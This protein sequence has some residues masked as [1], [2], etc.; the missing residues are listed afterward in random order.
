MANGTLTFG[1]F[2]LLTV[3]FALLLYSHESVTNTSKGNGGDTR[4]SARLWAMLGL[5]VAV[6][7][8]LG[9]LLGIQPGL[10]EA[11]IVF[12]AAMWTLYGFGKLAIPQ[13]LFRIEYLA[14]VWGGGELLTDDGEQAQR[15]IGYLYLLMGYVFFLLPL[16]LTV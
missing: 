2:A 14:P 6:G 8:L 7:G 9:Y 13:R 4:Q 11:T 5:G 15:Q 10:V 12:I 1:G 16:F 3:G